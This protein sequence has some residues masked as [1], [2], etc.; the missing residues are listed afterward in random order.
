MI[1]LGIGL[2]RKAP[3]SYSQLQKTSSNIYAGLRYRVT[4]KLEGLVA[5]AKVRHAK[6]ATF[7]TEGGKQ[8]L[9]DTNLM[10]K[11]C[12]GS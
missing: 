2:S 10:I 3:G 9:K 5:F 7:G 6:W 12:R 11:I 4:E 8:P 1:L